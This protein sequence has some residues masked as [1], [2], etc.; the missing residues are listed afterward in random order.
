MKICV[1]CGNTEND[2]VRECSNCG[3]TDL[4]IIT[5]TNYGRGRFSGNYELEID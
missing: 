5:K 1:V 4:R 2:N 3:N